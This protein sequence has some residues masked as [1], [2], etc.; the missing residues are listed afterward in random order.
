[1]SGG[2]CP[3]ERRIHIVIPIRLLERLDLERGA[4]NRSA[5]IAQILRERYHEDD[6]DYAAA[7]DWNTP[8]D[9][10]DF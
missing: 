3:G 9:G 8:I 10:D 7:E 2:P 5:F 6:F 4:E 1:M